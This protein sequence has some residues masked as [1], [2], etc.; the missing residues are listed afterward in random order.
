MRKKPRKAIRRIDGIVELRLLAKEAAREALE[1]FC[2]SRLAGFIACRRLAQTAPDEI[3]VA[4]QREYLTV[5]ETASR[6]GMK[7]HTLITSVSEGYFG[8]VE[9]VRRVGRRRV[10]IHWPTFERVVL[11][12]Q[13]PRA[14]KRWGRA[15]RAREA[16]KAMATIFDVIADAIGERLAWELVMKFGGAEISPGSPA[17]AN[18]GEAAT[19]LL[20]AL[21]KAGLSESVIPALTE[22]Q[23]RAVDR[24]LALR[25]HGF[26][27]PEL[28]HILR[29][30][31]AFLWAVLLE[32][33][34]EAITAG[35][36]EG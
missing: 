34:A 12:G 9:G 10:L 3:R 13:F 28:V 32:A 5:A 14:H 35:D 36:A 6:I 31:E 1:E 26:G 17:L 25:G 30:R 7:R 22:D 23:S 33:E 18:L 27:V 24:A 4:D 11:S 21:D 20:G 8:I 15:A 2:R 19:K 16:L 29:C